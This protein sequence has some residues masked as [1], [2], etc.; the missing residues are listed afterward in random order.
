MGSQDFDHTF[1][2]ALNHKWN[3]K[4]GFAFVLQFFS[5]ISDDLNGVSTATYMTLCKFLVARFF[6]LSRKM[7]MSTKILFIYQLIFY[8]TGF[9]KFWKSIFWHLN[10]LVMILI[11]NSWKHRRKK[12]RMFVF[13]NCFQPYFKRKVHITKAM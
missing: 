4:N 10:F 1:S 7:L 6:A 12:I 3:V 8:N 11:Y 5:L 9:I 2:M 13:Q